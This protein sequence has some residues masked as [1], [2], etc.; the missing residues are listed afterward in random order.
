MG[1]SEGGAS[2]N[3][4]SHHPERSHV[5]RTYAPWG[6]RHTAEVIQELG[7]KDIHLTITSVDLV[8][9]SLAAAHAFVKPG[10]VE[11]DLWRAYRDF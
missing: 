1:S 10:V 9:G 7:L 3:A 11:T 8:R 6:H 4:G 2:P 5:I